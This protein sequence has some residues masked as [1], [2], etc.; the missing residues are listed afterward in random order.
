VDVHPVSADDALEGLEGLAAELR[1]LAPK[2]PKRLETDEK[3]IEAGVAKLVLTLVEFIR[4]VLEHQAIRR[5]EG[6]TLTEVE[7]ERLGLALM[8][9]QEKLAE[10]KSAFGLEDDDLNV[11][12]GPLGRLL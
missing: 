1:E 10:L 11:D 12:L 3:D 9:L 2:L 6:G 8:R 7:V 4:Q 5:M